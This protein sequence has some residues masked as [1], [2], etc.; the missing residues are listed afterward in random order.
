MALTQVKT[1]GI[2]DD[3]V[4][5][6]KMAGG[7]DGRIITYDASGN[8]TTVGPGTDGQVLT[9]TGAGSPPAFED[10]APTVGGANGA[11]FNDNVQLK[12]GTHEDA[13]LSSTGTGVT[14]AALTPS[15]GSAGHVNIN[16]TSGNAVILNAAATTIAQFQDDLATLYGTVDIQGPDSSNAGTLKIE[17]SNSSPNNVSITVPDDG[18]TSN[19]TITLPAAAPASNGQA[20]TST[21]AGVASWTTITTSTN[22]EFRGWETYTSAGTH[23]WTKPSGLK[24]IKVY[25]TG[26]GGGGAVHSGGA[27]GGGAGATAIK[28]IEASALGATET[29]T[30]GAGGS[31]YSGSDGD[32]SNGS[33][34]TF[35]S[36]CKGDYGRGGQ[37][38]ASG[39]SNHTSS[40]GDLILRG[41]CGSAGINTGDSQTTFGGKG[42]DSF[43]GGGGCGAALNQAGHAA[44][45]YGGGGGSTNGSGGGAAYQGGNGKHGVCVVEQYF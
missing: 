27:W 20:L 35:G 11:T 21:T 17:D 7:T 3:A 32:G 42:G 23:T 18:V 45:A 34:T 25:V 24:R 14:L 26:G 2:A 13:S 30:V 1:T 6:D 38:D 39:G 28:V 15:S 10:A 41:G 16:T 31:G 5:T 29:V 33:A 43:W 8:P 40:G 4:T 36:H 37:T 22:G 44:D 9:S 19:Y 12:F